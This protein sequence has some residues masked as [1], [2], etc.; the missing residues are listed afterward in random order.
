M[1]RRYQQWFN[2]LKPG[3]KCRIQFPWVDGEYYGGRVVVATVKKEHSNKNRKLLSYRSHCW[4]RMTNSFG[5]LDSYHTVMPIDK[6]V[7]YDPRIGFHLQKFK[8]GK[9]IW[10]IKR[11]KNA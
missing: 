4:G 6:D 10:G 5:I 8:N 1:S 3:D 7:V 9:S 2:S 11:K